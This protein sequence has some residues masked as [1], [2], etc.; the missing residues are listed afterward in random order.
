[1]SS[2]SNVS[3]AATYAVLILVVVAG[4]SYLI[5]SRTGGIQVYDVYPT[6]SMIPTLEVGDLVVVESVPFSSLHV[7][8]VIVFG[9]P[10]DDGVCTSVDIV[11]RIVNITDGTLYTQGDN[12]VTNP[13]PDEPTEWPPVPADCVKGEVVFAIPYLGDISQAF[14]PPLNYI[15][16]AIIIIMVFLIEVVSGGKKEQQ[17]GEKD[18][19]KSAP[20]AG[21]PSSAA[22]LLP[23]NHSEDLRRE[24]VSG[25]STPT[26]ANG[27]SKQVTLVFRSRLRPC[28]VVFLRSSN[29]SVAPWVGDKVG[30]SGSG[31]RLFHQKN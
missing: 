24:P 1:M 7:G 5:N 12:R 13:I 17:E 25:V 31:F 28:T 29:R 8:D 23:S 6:G 22:S 21:P 2:R 11:H 9:K 15:L 16:V 20:E 26:A 3:R 10:S 18:P 4:A 27:I 19:A 30:R 14:P